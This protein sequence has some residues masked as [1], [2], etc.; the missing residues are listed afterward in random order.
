MILLDSQINH[1]FIKKLPKER[2]LQHGL[3][4]TGSCASQW[5]KH[6]A[7]A[8]LLASIMILL[9]LLCFTTMTFATSSKHKRH[10]RVMGLYSKV[11]TATVKDC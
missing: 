2:G 8:P 1:N 9:L 4:Q 10:A 3:Q 5:F 7:C 11:V 6:L